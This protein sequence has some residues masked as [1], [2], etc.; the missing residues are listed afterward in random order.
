MIPLACNCGKNRRVGD[1]AVSVPSTYRVF[2]N[3]HKVYESPSKDAA[4][5]LAARYNQGH[6]SAPIATTY[7]PGEPNPS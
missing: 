5:T 6:E 4:D 1:A 3:N 7:M 2:V